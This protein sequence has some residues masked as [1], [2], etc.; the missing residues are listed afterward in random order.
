MEPGVASFQIS[1]SG[2][3]Y[4][5][6]IFGPYIVGNNVEYSTKRMDSRNIEEITFLAV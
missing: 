6:V 4:M 3:L 1:P 5:I 2:L